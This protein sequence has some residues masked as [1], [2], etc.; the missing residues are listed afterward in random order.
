MT[1]ECLTK[2][3]QEIIEEKLPVPGRGYT[4]F[5]H[6]RLMETGRENLSLARLAEAHWDAVAILVEAGRKPKPGALYG[7]WAAEIPNQPLRLEYSGTGSRI[8]GSKMFCSGAGLV[9]RALVTLGLPEQQLVDIDLRQHADKI[10][11][12]DSGWK[13]TAFKETRT[14]TCIFSD[15]PVTGADIIGEA[16]WYLNRAGFWHGACGPAACWAGG[17][18]GLVDYAMQQRR[19]DAHTLAHLGAMHAALWSMQ[20]ALDAAG[21][22]IDEAPD[23]AQTARIR[24]R[25][26][27]H[28]VEQASTDILRRMTRAFG[29]YPLAMD[30]EISRRCQE[31]DLYLRQCHAERDLEVL[32]QDLRDCATQIAAS[33]SPLYS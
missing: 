30:E 13:T 12:D 4:S 9:D 33:T 29:P 27:R 11:F 16:G 2:R 24:A 21:H 18:A 7:V 23:D 3:L 25:T 8:N 6:R 17:A 31:L 32:G 19:K 14:A 28:L 10:S 1:P 26:V 5:R 15:I 20:A 22:E